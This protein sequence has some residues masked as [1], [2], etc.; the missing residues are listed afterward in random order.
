MLP[1]HYFKTWKHFKT[2]KKKLFMFYYNHSFD[3]D[4]LYW[5]TEFE[6]D[7]Y[8]KVKHKL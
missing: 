7:L 1:F 5:D 4:F 3:D 8:G 2:K 6:N